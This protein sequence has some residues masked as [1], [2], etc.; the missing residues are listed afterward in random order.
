[1]RS[2]GSAI[3]V[4]D[5]KSPESVPRRIPATRESNGIRDESIAWAPDGKRIA[6]L[7]DAE[8]VGQFQV[9]VADLDTGMANKLT[10][11]SGFLADPRWSADGKLA[12]LFTENTPRAAGPLM[13][14][15]PE[16][17]RGG[18]QDLRTACDHGGR[19]VREHSPAFA[20]RYVCL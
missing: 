19:C 16:D 4:Q 6:F 15:T 7:S 9:Y 10:S 20:A 14:M 2:E 12:I 3:Y 1:M 11:L 8:S 17:W 5:L 18:R 13:A